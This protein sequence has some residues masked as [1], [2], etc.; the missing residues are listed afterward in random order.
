MNKA[1]IYAFLALFLWGIHGPA[2]RYLAQNNVDMYFVFS[3]RLWIGTIVFFIYLLIKKN[4]KIHWFDNWKKVL[5]IS[6]IG[7]IANTILFHVTLI[8]LPGTLVMIL[9]NLSPV[10]V[11]T[12][13]IFY[14]GIKPTLAEIAALI[15]SFL[16]IFLIIM[17]KGSFPELSDGFYFGIFL[18]ILTGLTFGAYIFYSAE[19]VQPLKN[20][21]IRIIRFLFK[22]FL[23][24]SIAC[25]P[26]L[27]TSK[28][29]PS[30]RLEWFWLLE[31]GIFQS[32]L[33]Y[34]F[35]NYALVYIKANTAS[36]L[37][38]LT[39]LFTT[40][41][42]VVFMNLKLNFNL[43]AGAILISVAGYWITVSLRKEKIKILE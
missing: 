23:I 17:G 33:A 22:I 4:I 36:I 20:E 7:I 14:F 37:F 16:G 35:W 21:P 3:A 15:L 32:G 34:L 1:R 12:A 25:T 27:L 10:F 39:I 28:K 41:N 40:I 38:L 8:Y 9:E 18:G 24:S 19:L 42:E 43:V 11:L 6:G 26:F 5:L 13:S 31:M 2:G 30:T 29:L